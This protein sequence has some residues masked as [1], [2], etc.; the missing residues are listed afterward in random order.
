MSDRKMS[1]V[2]SMRANYDYATLRPR[3][4]EM[5]EAMGGGSI[6]K[7]NR[8]VIKPNLLAPAAP[9]RAIV[10]H[11]MLVKGVAE[12]VLDRG[13]KVQI[14]DS[15]AMGTFEKVL[16]ESGIAE[17]IKGL[18][19][20]CKEFKESTTVD[21]GEPFKKIE[22]AKD[23]LETDVLINLPKLKTHSQML[24]TLGVKNLFGCIVGFRKPQ[25][26][27]RAGVDREVFAKLLVRIYET[28]QPH[29]TIL[30]GIL[31]MEGE[32]PGRGGNPREV[33]ILLASTNAVALDVAVCRMLRVEEGDLLTNKM[34]RALGL[35][36][37][38]VEIVGDRVDISDFKL[39]EMTPL[40]FGPK[41]SQ[42]FLRKHLIQRPQVEESLCK[43]CGDC[44]RYCPAEA[45]SSRQKKIGFDYEKCIRCYCC[46]EVCPHGALRTHQP[47]LGKIVARVMNRSS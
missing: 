13:G 9:P 32:G 15:P 19:V 21:V 18:N 39:P 44:G 14:S 6:R 8:V 38:P 24:L 43:A 3:V 5:M 47:L 31:G 16:K 22:I 27:L 37:G 41:F 30:D 35:L 11:P 23:A 7:N 1:T 4:F 29:Y 12:Y 20:A 17:A 28:I 26:H 42:A 40:V 45:I 10:T 25:W 2:I 33:G 46:L 34:A 36:D